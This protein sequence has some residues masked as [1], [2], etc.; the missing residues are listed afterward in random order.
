MPAYRFSWTPFDDATIRAL[1]ADIGYHG[2]ADGARD[3]LM[4]RVL[5][6]NEDCVRKTKKS[7]E[8]VLAA[9]A[10]Q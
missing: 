1:A 8:K 6:S 5:R 9:T 7:I 2:A 3:F 10:E 4:A